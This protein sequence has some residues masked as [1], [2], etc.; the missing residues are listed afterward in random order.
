VLSVVVT[1]YFLKHDPALVESRLKVGPTAEHE[2]SSEGHSNAD[3]HSLVRP[4]HRSGN[5]TTLPLFAHSSG[6]R[7]SSDA[8]VAVGDYIVFLALRE[9]RWA[10]SIIEVRPGQ[11]VISIGP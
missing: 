9:N 6:A 7:S 10:A 5:R 3:G 2:K 8:L 11:S 1:L 4:H